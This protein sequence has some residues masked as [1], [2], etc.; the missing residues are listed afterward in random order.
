MTTLRNAPW[1]GRMVIITIALMSI[2]P[3][4]LA[5]YY[6]RHPELI[7]KTSNYGTLILPPRPFDYASL[8]PL[9]TRPADGL[10]EL[11]GRWVLLQIAIGPCREAC[12]KALYKTHQ[13][14]LMLNQ[15]MPRVKRL[16]LLSPETRPGEA[17]AL[18]RQD[19]A[20]LAADTPEPLLRTLSE[21][22]GKLPHQGMVMLLDPRANLILRYDEGFDPYKMLKDLK[23]LLRASRIG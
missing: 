10:A 16:L 9:A 17:E 14:W 4:G 6:V 13:V 12:A 5:W 1:R 21:A 23:H 3:F 11:E 2:I 22:A 15:E 19:G 8:R 7:H 20:L 18:L